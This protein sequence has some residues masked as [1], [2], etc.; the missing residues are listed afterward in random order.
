MAAASQSSLPPEFFSRP[1]YLTVSHQLHLEAL[2]AALGRVYTVGPCFRAERSLTGRHLAEFW[3]LEAEW[4]LHATHDTP[5]SIPGIDQ[6]CDL[7]ETCLRD[8]VGEAFV[9]GKGGEDMEVLWKGADERKRRVLEDAFSSSTQWER[10]TYTRAIAELQHASL[11]VSSPVQF[12]YTPKWGLPLQSEHE[13]WL[14]ETLVGAPVFITDYPIATKPFYMRTNDTAEGETVACCDLLVPHVGELAG[15]SVREERVNILERRMLAE[16]R[17]A[18][19]PASGVVDEVSVDPE[20]E[21]KKYEW[22]LDLRRYG[23]VPHAGFGMGFERL[24]GWV[25]GIDNVRECIPMPRWN[26]RMVL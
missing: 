23:G 4:G 7:I 8:I 19:A 17:A 2:H 14:A 12:Q 26:G 5:R 10:L 18:P 6:V 25:G 3:M 24:V 21:S 11:S 13:R 15:G 22:Y 20:P 1:A 9:G 16:L